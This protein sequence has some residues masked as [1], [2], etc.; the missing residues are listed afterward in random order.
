MMKRMALLF[1]L[2]GMILSAAKADTITQIYSSATTTT[3]NS[4]TQGLPKAGPTINIDQHP[5]WS[6]PLSGS[7]WVSFSTTGNPSDANFY[8]VPNGTAVTFAESFVLSG[9]ITSAFLNVLADDTTSVVLNGTQIYGPDLTGPYPTCSI[10]PIGCL[11]STEGTF[12]SAALLPYLQ[13]GMNTISFTVYQEGGSSYGLDYA[14]AITTKTP[15]PGTMLLL[16]AG[17]VGLMLF[18]LRN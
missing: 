6:A 12:N 5:S 7:N 15:E 8:T 17:V 2:G 10:T 16:G 18:K 4:A 11:N 14:G 13:D 3:N 1:V 9:T